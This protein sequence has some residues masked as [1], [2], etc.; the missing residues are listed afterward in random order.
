MTGLLF[1]SLVG[2]GWSVHKKPKFDVRVM[3]H[4]SG[5][6][7]RAGKYAMPMWEFEL[8][9]DGLDMTATGDYGSLG[10][11]SMQTLAGFFLQCQGKANPFVYVDP[12]DNLV[13][14]AYVGT[15]DGVTTT[16][17]L[18]RPMGAFAEPVGALISVS[19]VYL[20]GANIFGWI[21]AQPN[22]ITFGTPVPAGG[23]I[24]ASFK[25]GYACRFTEDVED[26]EEFMAMLSGV[27]TLQFQSVRDIVPFEIAALRTIVIEFPIG[28][29]EFCAPPD[30]NNNYNRVIAI[31][32]GGGGGYTPGTGGGGGA[33]T[34][35]DNVQL[36]PGQCVPIVIGAGG[37]P[38]GTGSDW[39]LPGV[40]TEFHNPGDPSYVYADA[41]GVHAVGVAGA[42]SGG[43]GDHC[44]P[45]GQS[46]GDGMT[47]HTFAAGCNGGGGAGGPFGPGGDGGSCYTNDTQSGAG[48][49][50]ADGGATAADPPAADYN[51]GLIVPGFNVATAG[52]AARDGTPGGAPGAIDT[53]P[54]TGVNGPG[55]AG[56]NGSGGGGGGGGLGGVNGSD[57]VT[58]YGFGDGGDG[59]TEPL[60]FFD[61]VWYGPGGGG[62]GAGGVLSFFNGGFAGKGGDGGKFGG[63]G[64][65]GGGGTSADGTAGRVPG[66]G[67]PGGLIIIYL[68]VESST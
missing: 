39:G 36:G 32:G 67:G 16:F 47:V 63:G 60:W 54:A 43:L 40:P 15:G 21:V 13:T 2:Q 55:G 57:G 37:P 23:V 62:G 65:G 58:M 64:G 53:R 56:K 6:E 26:F 3:P 50:G 44:I 51:I 34:Y 68:G 17:A 24:T 19:A 33:F 45:P 29:G 14:N 7:T 30:W 52:G 18:S 10:A 22:T 25:F 46:G 12:T 61:G 59:S 42:S 49:G 35:R 28:P 9:F 5:R 48:G 41:A 27:K 31:G 20:N 1:P 11:Q 66:K 8:T 4:V 38:H